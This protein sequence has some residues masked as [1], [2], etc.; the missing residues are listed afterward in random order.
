MRGCL[1]ALFRS[2][3]FVLVAV[4]AFVVL[5]LIG[6]IYDGRRLKPMFQ[7]RTLAEL[8][9]QF[10]QEIRREVSYECNGETVTCVYLRMTDNILVWPS[11]PPAI[12]FD[13]ND[14]LVATCSDTGDSPSFAQKWAL[15]KT[16]S[17]IFR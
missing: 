6:A 10:P 1:T 17:K 12:I 16:R 4:T 14:L 3:V 5:T 2:L 15:H 7:V 13:K 11:G 8:K 9:E